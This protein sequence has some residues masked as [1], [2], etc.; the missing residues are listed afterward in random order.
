M[1]TATTDDI[2]VAQRWQQWA[3]VVGAW[4]VGAL[5]FFRDTIFSGFDHI[6]SDDG[7][8]RL[9]VYLH[10]HWLEVVK[11]NQPWRTPGFFHD[12]SVTLGYSDTF[13]LN[14]VFYAPL[15]L[16]GAD[17]YLAMQLTIIAL[18]LVGFVSFHTVCTRLLGAGRWLS[19][20]FAGMFVFANNMS[21]KAGH[22][23]LLSV[24]WVPLG[25]LLVAKA[26][27]TTSRRARLA[28]WFGSGLFFGT[29][30][31]SAYYIGWFT[32]FAALLFC[33]RM[34]VHLRHRLVEQSLRR[35]AA[36][37]WRPVAAFAG[38]LA[39]PMVPFLLTYLPKLDETGGR[40]L[41]SVIAGAP[42]I[43]DAVNVGTDNYL[44]GGV[45]RAYFGD[46]YRLHNVEVATA[47]TPL[48]M[49]STVVFAVVIAIRLRG[50]RGAP[51]AVARSLL[52]VSLLIAVLPLRIGDFSLWRAV[53]MFVPGAKALR[54]VGR[55]ELMVSLLAPLAIAASI[56]ALREAGRTI[57]RH[58][59]RAQQVAVAAWCLLLLFEQFNVSTISRI[60]RS[61]QMAFIDQLADP[62][63][64]CDSFFILVPDGTG[65]VAANIDAMIVAQVSGVPTVNGYSGS[66]PPFWDLNPSGEQYVDW[67]QRWNG[68]HDV[69]TSCSYDSATNTWDVT[70]FD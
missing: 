17:R 48:L 38:G 26:A 60:D 53:W 61:T 24:Y 51:A 8:G 69:G 21:V 5:V 7:D 42:G 3:I 56:W 63:G 34:A 47:A 68:R 58:R 62:P 66:T 64:E 32:A 14:E 49:L 9:I 13:V 45:L 2:V 35:L 10:E 67:V 37:V 40:P 46:H 15:R 6:I 23:Q 30:V 16:V 27:S 41:R 59:P 44:W 25:V 33:V 1:S 36:S 29:L 43:G 57:A 39:V 20:A 11:G 18:S 31:Y 12:T 28:W 19:L 4:C 65:D 52:T 70:P 55:I 54:A 50:D 22:I